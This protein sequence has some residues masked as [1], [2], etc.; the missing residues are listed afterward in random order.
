MK[1]LL[2]LS[3]SILL[4]SSFSTNNAS[5]ISNC[6]SSEYVYISDVKYEGRDYKMV[7]MRRENDRI[8][9][10]Y[11]AAKDRGLS[12]YERYLEWKKYNP[13]IVLISSGTYYDSYKNP[14]GLTID[15]G[16]IVNQNLIKDRMDA[17]VIVYATGGIAVSNLRDGD[18]KVEGINR[19]LNLRR[20]VTDLVDF[21]EWSKEKE[22]TVFQTHLLVFKNQIKIDFNTS[23][24]TSR[25][26][27]FLAVGKENGQIVHAIIHHSDY[28]T[29]YEGTRRVFEFLREFRN[30]DVAFMINLDT[31][32]QDVFELYNSNCSLNST[33]KGQMSVSEAVN[34]LVYHFK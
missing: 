26:R 8:K 27:R 20:S 1:I 16:V 33:I 11:F 12:V 13:N 25:E 18:L 17:L 24:G 23:S 10:K 31:G 9:A 32:A 28:T 2:L 29:I 19:N 34:M 21:I 14:Q 7:V 4:F 30:M 22:A 6:Y 3:F 15:N 5:L